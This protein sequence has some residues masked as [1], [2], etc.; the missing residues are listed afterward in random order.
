MNSAFY[1]FSTLLSLVRIKGSSLRVKKPELSIQPDKHFTR[2]V[3][4]EP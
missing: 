3:A 2:H 1:F 4:E